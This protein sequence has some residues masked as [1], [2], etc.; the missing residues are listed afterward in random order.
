[1]LLKINKKVGSNVILHQPFVGLCWSISTL[2]CMQITSRFRHTVFG[3][4]WLW[5]KAWVL[6]QTIVSRC[7]RFD[8][9]SRIN[10]D[11]CTSEWKIYEH[12]RQR[13]YYIVMIIWSDAPG[14]QQQS[15]VDFIMWFLWCSLSCS[16][17]FI[18]SI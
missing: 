8:V 14:Q 11:K 12:Y 16:T 1:M 18:I 5:L 6:E 4:I 7:F 15:I 9:F 13:S 2:G 17:S 3:E 10:M